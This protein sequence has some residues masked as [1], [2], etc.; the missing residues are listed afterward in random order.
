M[1]RFLGELGTS[2]RQAAKHLCES[3]GDIKGFNGQEFVLIGR[4]QFST[5]P[6]RNK[7]LSLISEKCASLHQ[8]ASCLM[9]TLFA[10]LSVI[11]CV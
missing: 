7:S 3:R 6:F 4:C 5:V 10:E 1:V 8:L 9:G 11:H 2:T